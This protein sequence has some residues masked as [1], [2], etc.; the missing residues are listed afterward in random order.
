METL[1]QSSSRMTTKEMPQSE[2]LISKMSDPFLGTLMRRET[3]LDGS[4]QAVERLLQDAYINYDRAFDSKD[5]DLQMYW[6]GAI[7]NLHYVLEMD[8]Q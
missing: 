3:P 7:R 5:R 8:G 1:A 4:R 2:S 6:D